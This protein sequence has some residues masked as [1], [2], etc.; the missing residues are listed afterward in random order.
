MIIDLPWHS[1]TLGQI[2]RPH[3]HDINA[4]HFQDLGGMD[5][6]ILDMEH[7]PVSL[8]SLQNI[9]SM[10]SIFMSVNTICGL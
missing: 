8:E 4:R 5:F 7:G 2:I 10:P 1:Q 9:P 6:A 3:K